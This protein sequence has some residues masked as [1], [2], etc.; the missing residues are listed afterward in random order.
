MS[1]LTSVY[2]VLSSPLRNI[3]F[4]TLRYIRISTGAGAG[5]RFFSCFLRIHCSHP[6]GDTST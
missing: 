6:F 5:V 1:L 4:K 3:F 2:F